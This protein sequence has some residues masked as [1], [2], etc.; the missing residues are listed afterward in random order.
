MGDSRAHR[1][2]AGSLFR[3]R[4]E[5]W[6]LYNNHNGCLEETLWPEGVVCPAAGRDLEELWWRTVVK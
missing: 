6:V 5:R 3:Q 4:P 1:L 2:I